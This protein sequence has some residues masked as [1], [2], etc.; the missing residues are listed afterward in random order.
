MCSDWSAVPCGDGVSSCSSIRFLRWLY[1][2][3]AHSEMV[4]P[5][6]WYFFVY[7]VTF[8]VSDLYL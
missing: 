2:R 6:E 7:I 1:N 8:T 5:H 3:E 4:D